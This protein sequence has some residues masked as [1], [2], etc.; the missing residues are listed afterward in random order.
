[1]VEDHL[2]EPPEKGAEAPDWFY[3]LGVPPMLDGKMRRS[4]VFWREYIP[5]LIAIELAIGNT[6]VATLAKTA[7]LSES[8]FQDRSAS[9]QNLC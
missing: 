6:S 5:P 4:Y 9:P 8:E 3:V 2:G 7:S 1:M